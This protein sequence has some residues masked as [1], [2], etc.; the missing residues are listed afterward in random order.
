MEAFY[1]F[2]AV[3][4]RVLA[5]F[6]RYY[7]NTISTFVTLTIIFALIAFGIRNFAGAS[8][9]D[10]L[11]DTAVGYFAWT[12]I[13]TTVG[14]LSWTLMNEMSRGLIEQV[15]TSPFGPLTVYTLYEAVNLIISLPLL[16]LLMVVI[17]LLAKVSLAVPASFFLILV[18]MM[19]QSM[20]IGLVFGGITLKFK[21]T[22][23]LLQVVNFAVIGLFFL[24]IPKWAWI[25]VPISPHF[26][27]MKS[28]LGGEGFDVFGYFLSLLSTVIYLFIGIL[29]FNFFV[30]SVKKTGDLTVY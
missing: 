17:F 19:I 25:F 27:L 22:N 5:E 11:R 13:L 30:R 8:M 18:T 20:G 15:F 12:A 29:T 28:V 21:R 2:K 26:H 9:G 24:K 10:S 14:D 16:Y 1:L 23:A 4:L 3:F 7:L 6:K